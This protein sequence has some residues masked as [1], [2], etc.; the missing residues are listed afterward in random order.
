MVTSKGFLSQ[1]AETA[2]FA[3]WEYFRPLIA[4][5]RYLKSSMAPSKV[6]ESTPED[7]ASLDDAQALLRERL[8]KGRHHE[9]S[10]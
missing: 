3:F 6:A 9:K 2:S 5:A 8:A 1:T 10:S 4:V 7:Q